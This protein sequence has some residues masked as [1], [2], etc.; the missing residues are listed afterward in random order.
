MDNHKIIN[1]YTCRY[2]EHCFAA[3]CI[4]PYVFL[5]KK[6]YHLKSV[7]YFSV[8]GNEKYL[9]KSESDQC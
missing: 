2:L 1:S 9:C 5:L 4:L 8:V 6:L 3:S 7:R